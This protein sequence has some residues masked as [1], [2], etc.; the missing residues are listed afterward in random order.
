MVLVALSLSIIGAALGEAHLKETFDGNSLF[1]V[2]L[3]P[4]S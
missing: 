1:E 3:L 4:V 2:L